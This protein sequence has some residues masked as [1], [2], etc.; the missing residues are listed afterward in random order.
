[1]SEAEETEQ[2][3]RTR[4]RWI[5]VSTAAVAILLITMLVVVKPAMPDRITLLAGP[6]GSPV[7]GVAESYSE[8]LQRRGLEAE[9]VV[10]EGALDSM[11]RLAESADAVA[12]VSAAI[13]A[14]GSSGIDTTRLVALGSIGFSH[15]W[16]FHRSDL[17]VTSVQDLVGRKVATPGRET[18]C[19]LVVRKLLRVHDLTGKVDLRPIAGQT[20]HELVESFKAG[21][22]D[23]AFVTGAADSELV[24]ALFDD[25]HSRFAPFRHAD[26]YAALIPG[27]VSE[28]APEG[29]FNLTRNIPPHDVRLLA[30]T[31][32]LVANQGLHP[33]IAPMLLLTAENV[34]EN[35]M[36]FS[37]AVTFPSPRNLTLPLDRGARRYFEQGETGLSRFLS[38]KAQRWVNHLVFVLLPLFAVV[39]VLL[40]L[41]TTGVRAWSGFKLKR[42]F[43]TLEA[44]EKGHAAG[45]D[46]AKLL[47]D[48]DVLDRDSAAMFVPMSTVQDYVDFRQFL[49]DMR[50]RVG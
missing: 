8:D 32:C 19:D 28:T 40:K 13:T 36:T 15:L 30:T 17:D 34:R 5:A 3:G 49:H 6:E 48:L 16:L 9:V 10:T 12:F 14:D 23:A 18:A 47:G 1:M 4:S 46:C 11:R 44:V 25:E 50:E 26:A 21:T 42:M 24:Q 20:A 22:L 35:A 43:K 33:A 31:G 45:R 29:V 2:K 39:A 37:P 38:Y 41:V 27:V 7:H